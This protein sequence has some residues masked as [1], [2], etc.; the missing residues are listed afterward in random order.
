M[1]AK[2]TAGTKSSHDGGSVPAATSSVR[3]TTHGPA[4][5]KLAAMWQCAALCRS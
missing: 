5:Y 2:A 3:L 4:M 1:S